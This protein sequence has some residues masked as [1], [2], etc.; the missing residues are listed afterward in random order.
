[1]KFEVEKPKIQNGLSYVLKTSM[2]KDAVEATGLDLNIHLIYWNPYR[3]P[4]GETILECHYWLPNENV[5]YDRFYIRA[6]TV[7][8]ENRKIAETLLK[9]EV[10]PKFIDWIKDLKSLPKNS[11]KLKNN[12]YFN[13]IFRENKVIYQHIL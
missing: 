6:G 7:K 3:I 11:T 12:L 2:L 4:I 10:L 13:A 1:M 9:E 8:S 5:D